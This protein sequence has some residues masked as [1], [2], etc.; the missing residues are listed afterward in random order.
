MMGL[1]VRIS[2]GV[3]VRQ[4]PQVGDHADGGRCR[5][6]AAAGVVAPPTAAAEHRTVSRA[7]SRVSSA[8]RSSPAAPARP[9]A[10]PQSD[11]RKLKRD[12]LAT[13]AL[14]RVDGFPGPATKIQLTDI[15]VAGARFRLPQAARDRREG[16]DPRRGRP[17]PLDHPP[18]RR[19][20]HPARQRFHKHRLRVS[21][22]PS[23]SARG[24]RRHSAGSRR[25]RC[26]SPAFGFLQCPR[27][28]APAF[29]SRA[30]LSSAHVP[31]L[32]HARFPRHWRRH[33]AAGR[34]FL[35]SGDP[36]LRAFGRGRARLCGNS[37]DKPDDL[38][39]DQ[40]HRGG[41]ADFQIA[42]SAMPASKTPGPLRARSFRSPARPRPR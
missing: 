18:P 34:G 19:A 20:L 3:S 33:Q 38:R 31:S 39:R 5:P 37:E 14:L 9:A 17:I 40:P 35:R 12:A 25:S 7:E 24:P 6:R 2:A 21:S 15:S 16:T 23:C 42:T 28:I 8:A 1:H 30:H 22:A 32:S 36:D 27:A 13:A 11:R 26:C 4:R 29:S 10:P 41:A